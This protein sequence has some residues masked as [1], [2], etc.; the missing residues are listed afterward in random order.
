[1]DDVEWLNCLRAG[2]LM[3]HGVMARQCAEGPLTLAGQSLCLLPPVGRA[4]QR[5]MIIDGAKVKASLLPAS[6][7]AALLDQVMLSE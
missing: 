7:W 4:T 3:P 5:N 6:C 2:T 1:M